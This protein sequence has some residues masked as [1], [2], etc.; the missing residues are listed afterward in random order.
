MPK[1]LLNLVLR[2]LCR[3]MSEVNLCINLQVRRVLS[4]AVSAAVAPALASQRGSLTSHPSL[5]LPRLPAAGAHGLP[6][7]PEAK[8]RLPHLQHWPAPEWPARVA[9]MPSALGR[10]LSLTPKQRRQQRGQQKP[11][12]VTPHRQQGQC[13][14]DG[15]A[16]ISPVNGG[17]ACGSTG[18]NRAALMDLCNCNSSFGAA[19]WDGQIHMHRKSRSLLSTEECMNAYEGSDGGGA[20]APTSLT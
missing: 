20:E 11:L 14:V 2:L 3:N 12:A 7:Q 8:R 10:R 13:H 9:R 18:N 17:R 4:A 6:L 5:L 16:D 15:S 1:P 19:A